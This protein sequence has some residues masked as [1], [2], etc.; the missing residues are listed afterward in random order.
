MDA[1]SIPS[2]QQAAHRD[3]EV[4]PGIPHRQGGAGRHC[5][6]ATEPPA[7][8]KRSAIR[9]NP[10]LPRDVLQNSPVN[11]AH[12]VAT[13]TSASRRAASECQLGLGYL[14]FRRVS[15]ERIRDANVDN[16]ARLGRQR[17]SGIDN[18]A[19]KWGHW[20]D[21]SE[22]EWIE[23]CCGASSLRDGSRTC[24]PRSDWRRHC[25]RW[26]RSSAHTS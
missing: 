24:W 3:F 6:W 8:S 9:V 25:Q 11:A 12:S 19:G 2:A 16:L 18:H 5:L 7:G 22:H 10:T 4:F 17:S 20:R 15:N 14:R 21:V 13:V 26:W 23:W 1:S